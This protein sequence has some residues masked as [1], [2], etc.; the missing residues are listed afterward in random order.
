MKNVQNKERVSK[1]LNYYEP[2]VLDIKIL[3][4]LINCTFFIN[5]IK[6][7]K[8]TFKNQYKYNNIL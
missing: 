8:L 2:L 3:L 7:I 1:F 6:F 4:F 5:F